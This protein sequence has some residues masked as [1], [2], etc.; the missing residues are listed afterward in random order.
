MKSPSQVHCAAA[1]RVMRYLQ[2][3]KDY[4]MWYRSTPDIRIV[5]GKVKPHLFFVESMKDKMSNGNE[6]KYVITQN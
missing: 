5:T 3:T 6:G 1:K 4:G 2:G